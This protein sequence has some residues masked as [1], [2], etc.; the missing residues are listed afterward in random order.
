MH[1]DTILCINFTNTGLNKECS[2]RMRKVFNTNK[3]LILLDLDGNPNMD[4][5]DVIFIEDRL[6]ENKQLHDD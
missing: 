5:N 4:L 3:T 2:K 1:N 6:I